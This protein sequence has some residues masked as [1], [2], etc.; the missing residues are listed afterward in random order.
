MNKST[1]TRIGI[2]GA[3][4]GAGLAV[5]GVSLANAADTATPDSS[6]SS[7]DRPGGPR[8]DHGPGQDAAALAKALGLD[9]DKV[10]TALK[11]ARDELKPD[12]ADGATPTPPTDAERAEHRAKLAALLAK[13]LGVSEEKVTAALE[14]A[15]EQAD[16]DREERRT[17]ERAALVTRLDTAVKAGTLTEADKTSVLKAFDAKLIGGGGH[18]GPGG[19]G[20]TPPAS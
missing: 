18:G 12:T 5:G 17:Q 1:L 3:V 16:A 2:A 10:A 7:T 8:G 11:E 9:E 19:P 4:A 14:A 15:Q 6:S 13:K 20:G